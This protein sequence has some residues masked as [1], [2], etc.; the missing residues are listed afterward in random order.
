MG[1]EPAKRGG[2]EK[3][4]LGALETFVLR[5]IHQI[6][7]AQ[8]YN[9]QPVHKI[10]KAFAWEKVGSAINPSLAL[11]NHSCDSNA[12]RCSVNKSSI[13][14]AAR[15]I[16]EDEEIT[17]SYTVHFRASDR[18]ARLYHTLKNYMFECECEA[19]KKNWPMQGEVREERPNTIHEI[20][21]ELHAI[22]SMTQEKVY[23][24]CFG[25][26]KEC[27]RKIFAERKVVE[28]LMTQK[29]FADALEAYQD[30]CET[31]EKHVRRPHDY[32]LQCRS[33]IAHCIWNLYCTQFPE[34]PIDEFDESSRDL[35]KEI[36]KKS[37]LVEEIPPEYEY[38][39]TTEDT[40]VTSGELTAED[41]EKA[42]LLEA[43]KKMVE[44]SSQRVAEARDGTEA[45]KKESEDAKQAFVAQQTAAR[46]TQAQSDPVEE[47]PKPVVKSAEIALEKEREKTK[48]NKKEAEKEH[49]EKRSRKKQW[50]AEDNER[51]Q[52][53]NE[54]R[55][56][57]ERAM[58]E[59]IQQEKEREKK[60]REMKKKKKD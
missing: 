14:V 54:C 42:A 3:K 34:K 45:L 8:V 60:A 50:E 19:C 55:K 41:K 44:E 59:N 32:F 39:P 16:P 43:T 48:E 1:A 2:G 10:T 58:E 33:G 37:N 29:K 49:E 15:H 57:R 9:A 17:E 24:V 18:D 25:D 53:E 46:E 31:L 28:K 51:K 21:D 35:A 30:L 7:C 26:K 47:L 22:P 36:Y 4:S 38:T 11:V 23:K 5:L 40:E 52:R 6:G 27:V 56:K 12:L 13:L 20:P